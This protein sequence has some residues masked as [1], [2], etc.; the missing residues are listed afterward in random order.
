VTGVLRSAQFGRQDGRKEGR[1]LTG[2]PHTRKGY[3]ETGKW[4]AKKK[5]SSIVTAVV[6]KSEDNNPSAPRIKKADGKKGP[7]L[8]TPAEYLHEGLGWGDKLITSTICT[9]AR[10]Q[11]ER[12]RT[13]GEKTKGKINRR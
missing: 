6:L 2:N 11:R 3:K 7:S 5:E 12:E 9:V 4:R 10:S 1:Y 8:R 13:R